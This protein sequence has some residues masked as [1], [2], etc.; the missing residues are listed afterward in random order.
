MKTTMTLAV[1]LNISVFE[2]FNQDCDEVIMLINYYILLGDEKEG[3]V[4][5]KNTKVSKNNQRI[6]VN[7]D[8]ATG[9]WF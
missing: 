5:N 8:T 6:R 4:S 7:D 3:Q 1:N 9:G 2:I